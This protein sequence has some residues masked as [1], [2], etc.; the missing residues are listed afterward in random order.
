MI[1]NRALALL[2]V[3]GV[4]LAAPGCGRAN[5]DAIR[6]APGT[7]GNTGGASGTGGI[8]G[9]GGS[10]G[11][12]GTTSGGGT[13]AS[14]G[15]TSS[16]GATTCPSSALPTGDTSQTVQVG[17]STT[18]RS[19]LLHVPAAYDGSKPVPLILD[20][21]FLSSSG[22]RQRATSPYPD[23]V[24]GEGVIMA[25]PNGLT[26]PAGA[27]WNV[28]PCCVAGV[29]DVAFARAVVEQ[30]Q[31]T[32]CIDVKRVYAV[33]VSMG[34][35]L[36]YYL[37][38]HAADMFA[39]VAASAFDLMQENAVN[40]KPARPISVISFRGTGD[41]VV[42]Y[43][44]GPSTT[45]PGMKVTFLGAVPTFEKWAELDQCTGA[46]SPPD[47][48]NGCSEYSSCQGGVEVVLCTKQGGNQ[49]Q[50]NASIAWPILKRHTL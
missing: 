49:E 29:D 12:G 7:G 22:A 27:G 20:F 23:V 15:S 43:D 25:F 18:S 46:A 40:C 14:G 45:V 37:A 3:L 19:Y 1:L 2:G 6:R 21:H 44:G 41:T 13:S 9:T 48:T 17:T 35:G 50:G 11:S 36:A 4:A 16:G 26:G 34:G 30:I 5:L 33:G 8:V 28:G 31:K 39:A 42:P 32:A 10:T 38:C 47:S 24:D